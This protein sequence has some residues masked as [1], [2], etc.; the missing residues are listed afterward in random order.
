MKKK[1]LFKIIVS[2]FFLLLISGTIFWFT[3]IFR[4]PLQKKT[5]VVNGKEILAWVA[6][7]QSAR[8]QGLQNI[9]WLPKSTGMLFVFDQPGQYCFWN[10]NTPRSLKLIFMRDGKVTEEANLQSIWK[11]EQTVCPV[12]D[13]DSVLEMIE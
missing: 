6:D 12:H 13:I 1:R 2:I 7:T 8:E 5:R 9:I 10:K 4:I 11:G 3:A